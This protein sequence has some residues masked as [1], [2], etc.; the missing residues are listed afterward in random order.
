MP[1][2]GLGEV[3]S[4]DLVDIGELFD[5]PQ[6]CGDPLLLFKFCANCSCGKSNPKLYR[7]QV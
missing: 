5:Y 4:G 2:L 7:V 1:G 3:R 6:L